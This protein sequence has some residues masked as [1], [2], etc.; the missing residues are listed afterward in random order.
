MDFQYKYKAFVKSVYDGDTITCEIDCGF[1]IQFT[2]KIRLLGI[3][4]PE[5]RGE[6]KK[7]G[8][9]SRDALRERIANETIVLETVKDKRGKYG[10]ILGTIYL[11]NENINEWMVVN[12]YAK[13]YKIN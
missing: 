8:I 5:L 9:I 6:E 4:A 11:N 7:D 2:Q 10:R 13:K 3:N 12:G 1:K